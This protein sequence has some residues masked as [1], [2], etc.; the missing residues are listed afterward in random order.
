MKTEVLLLTVSL[1]AACALS[2]CASGPAGS[3]SSSRVSV[4]FVEP[5][6]FTDLKI[7]SRTGTDPELLD[8][9][10]YFMVTT[11]ERFVPAGMRLEIKVS[12]VDMA[13]GFAVS[14]GQEY[15]AVRAVVRENPPRVK[16][17]FSLT[18]DKGEI[19]KSGTRDISDASFM[20][21]NQPSNEGA[22]SYEKNML[23]NW[24]NDEFGKIRKS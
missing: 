18:N 1:G 7:D 24:F 10:Q 5:Q 9:L 13:G 17:E 3:N 4:V 6:R 22:L 2:G 16:L 12:D 19:V 23:R 21:R 20:S 8:Q 15:A 11:G 14:L